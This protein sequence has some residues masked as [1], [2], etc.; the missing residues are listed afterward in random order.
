MRLI[1]GSIV[2]VALVALSI[3]AQTRHDPD[4]ILQRSAA[5]RANNGISTTNALTSALR[6]AEAPGGIAS[7]GYCGEDATYPFGQSGPTLGDVLREIVRTN[8]HYTWR[9]KNGVVNVYPVE[10]DPALLK[11]VIGR[12]DIRKVYSVDD[13]VGRLFSLPEVQKRIRELNLTPGFVRLGMSDL[14]RSGISVTAKEQH[15]D[16]RNVTVR[17]ALNSIARRHGKAVW[18]YRENS[19]NGK[20]EFQIQFLVR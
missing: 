12:I 6:A 15:Y 7:V 20:T 8:P 10:G 4:L 18:R 19:C 14:S 5:I 16:L 1:Q 2:V 9:V 17:E 11:L 3:T 13:A